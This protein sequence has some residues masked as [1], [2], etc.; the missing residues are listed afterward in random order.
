VP[1]VFTIS[2]G[3]TKSKRK[4]KN[5]QLGDT[6]VVGFCKTTKNP[7]T[8]CSME[9]CYVGIGAKTKSGK[10]SR[11]GWEFKQGSSRCSRR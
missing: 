5:V 3:E 6:P 8:G 1:S 4:R 10:K 7:R 11:T 9:L 2:G